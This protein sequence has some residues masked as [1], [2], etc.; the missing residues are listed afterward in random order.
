MKRM[1]AMYIENPSFERIRIHGI[2]K[3]KAFQDGFKI[4]T[5]MIKLFL[6]I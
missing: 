6:K 4:L 1:N 5:H 3:V 2:K